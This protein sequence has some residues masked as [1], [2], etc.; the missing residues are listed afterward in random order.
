MKMKLVTGQDNKSVLTSFNGVIGQDDV[1]NKLRFLIESHSADTPIPTLLLTGSHGL[2]K[3][4]LA[5]KVSNCL[6]RRFVEVNCEMIETEK[7]LFDKILFGQVAGETPVTILFDEAHRLSK[8][9]ETALLSLLSP[10][11]NH[12]NTVTYGNWDVVFDMRLIN[13][14]FATTDAHKMFKPLINRAE[15]IYFNTYSNND[16]FEIIKM[17]ASGLSIDCDETELAYAARARARDAY[18]LAQHLKRMACI[19][20]SNTITNVEWNKL[21][22]ILQLNP[23]GL[24]NEE[25]RLLKIVGEQGPISCANIAIIM[26]VNPDNIS[27]ELEIRPRELGLIKNTT[28]GRVLTDEGVAYL[29]ALKDANLAL[30]M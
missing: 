3:T 23:M 13:V 10:T 7:D 26:M 24:K 18:N 30:T 15:A 8:D 21:K 20:G 1:L 22:V 29:D 16:L 2:G 27:D 9:V 6:G 11:E 12:I 14:I 5:K 4:Y 25:L 17:Y 19:V 28:K